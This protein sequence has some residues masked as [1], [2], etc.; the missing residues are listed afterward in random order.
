[1]A[2]FSRLLDRA[3]KLLAIAFSCQRGFEAAFFTGWDEKGM[4]LHFTNYVFLLYF[5]LETPQSTLERLAIA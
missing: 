4:S 5:A 3:A 1:M 2:P